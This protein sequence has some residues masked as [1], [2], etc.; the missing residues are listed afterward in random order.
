[1]V[2][3][4]KPLIIAARAPESVRKLSTR[5]DHLYK[6]PPVWGFFIWHFWVFLSYK[7]FITNKDGYQYEHD[8]WLARAVL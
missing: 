2:N 6:K 3:W 1:M 8:E 5:A 7:A 4:E